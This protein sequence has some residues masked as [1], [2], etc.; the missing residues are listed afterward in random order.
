MD[1]AAS[2]SGKARAAAYA[3]LDKTLMTKYAPAFPLYVPTFRYLVAKR[4]K[5]VIYSNYF[6]YP[7][8]NAMSVG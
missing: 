5:N 6:G 1:A 2:K 8:L 4:V 3:K 7:I